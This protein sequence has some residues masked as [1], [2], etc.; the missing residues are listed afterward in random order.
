VHSWDESFLAQT[1]ARQVRRNVRDVIVGRHL[2]PS[3]PR[4]VVALRALRRYDAELHASV[5]LLVF[6]NNNREPFLTGYHLD[7]PLAE[8]LRR[9]SWDPARR[10]AFTAMLRAHRSADVPGL[11]GLARNAFHAPRRIVATCGRALAT[12]LE[13]GVPR[14]GSTAGSTALAGLCFTYINEVIDM[15]QK[16]LDDRT[17]TSTTT[18]SAT[19]SR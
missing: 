8:W 4:E 2:P 10:E 17:G 13:S 19:W 1:V 14:P 9:T 11:V 15:D 16:D 6:S 5:E 12:S 3:W 18:C 7:Q